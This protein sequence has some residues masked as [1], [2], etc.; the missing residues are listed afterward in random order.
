MKPHSKF[1]MLMFGGKR[2]MRT[3]E[4]AKIEVF[5]LVKGSDGSE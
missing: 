5:N 2:G 3:S 1:N 4:S